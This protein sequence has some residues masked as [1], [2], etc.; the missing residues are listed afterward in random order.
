MKEMEKGIVLLLPP[1]EA[2]RLLS[3]SRS[4]FYSQCSAGRIG[5]LPQQFG[6]KKLY[7]AEELAQWVRAGCP[8]RE[9]S[10]LREEEL[11]A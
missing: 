3:M 8:P 10:W 11:S 2:A 4:H 1:A 5:P 7:V 6:R 9:Q